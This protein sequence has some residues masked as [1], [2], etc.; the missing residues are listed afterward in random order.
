VAAVYHDRKNNRLVYLG[1]EATP[2]FWDEHWH[3]ENYRASIEKGRNNRFILNTL[4]KYIPDKKGRILEGGCGRGQVVYCMHA[5]GYESIGVDWA[6]KTVAR[7]KEV[8]P[9]LDV[10]VGDLTSLPFPDN[11]FV[12]YWSLGV[13]EHFWE[14]YQPI[15]TEMQRVLIKG[16]YVF[17][18]FPYLSPLRKIKMK[19]NIY[20]EIEELT[21]KQKERFYQFALDGRTVMEDFTA[22]EFKLLA[23]KPTSGL[24]GFKDEVVFLKPMLQRLFDYRGSNLLIRGLSYGLEKALAT[25]AGHQIFIVFQKEA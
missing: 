13:I 2:D 16:G 11:Y 12:G 3:S 25:F 23:K 24:K 10:R 7:T 19:L 6:E 22:A 1:E 17:L 20:P 21:G 14:G 4:R 15:L 18:S 5:H 8:F 9:E